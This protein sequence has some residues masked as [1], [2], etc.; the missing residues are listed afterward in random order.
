MKKNS[1]VP[2]VFLV[3]ASAS[4]WGQ[5][6]DQRVS[7]AR[8]HMR[9]SCQAVQKIMKATADERATLKNAAMRAVEQAAGLWSLLAEE[10]AATVP[11][12]YAG[13]PGW[14][15]RL[16]DIRLN[17]V[18]MKAE[19]NRD[20]FRPAFLSCAHACN[21]ITAMHEANG[22]QLAIDA[23]AGLRKKVGF[24][25]GLLSAGKPEKAK[26]LIREI[27]TAR[28]VILLSP[29]PVNDWRER[30]VEMLPE[31][32]RAI[33]AVAEAVRGQ[34]DVKAALDQA[35]TVVETVYELAI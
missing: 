18:R 7:A 24:A 26:G 4:I 8:L 23:M 22:V 5:S 2:F 16:E 20:E 25:R 29:L 32:S 12:G 35:A 10:F 30:Y 21:L 28:D 19:I 33:D 15:Q 1:I 17:V 31:L 6:F 9:A 14:A 11:E 34:A 13:D 27:L 3:V